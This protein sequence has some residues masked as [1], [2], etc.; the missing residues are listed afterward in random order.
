[1]MISRV[2]KLTGIKHFMDLPVTAEQ[3]VEWVN[4]KVIQEAMPQLTLE[5]AEFLISGIT[6]EEWDSFIGKEEGE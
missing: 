5:Q 2:S 4:G 3:L 6:P 1:M